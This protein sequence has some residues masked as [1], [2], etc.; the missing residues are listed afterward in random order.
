MLKH[1]DVLHIFT[2]DAHFKCILSPT[3]PPEKLADTVVTL[4]SVK[5]LLTWINGIKLNASGAC[6]CV[7]D[8]DEFSKHIEFRRQIS[9]MPEK[10]LI[11]ILYL[12]F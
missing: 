8:S 2:D 4:F 6:V 11:R 10:E 1:M 9:T 3:I 7:C 12:R 5:V